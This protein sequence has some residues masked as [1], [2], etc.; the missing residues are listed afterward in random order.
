MVAGIHERPQALDVLP[1]RHVHDDELV[2]VDPDRRRVAL[3]GLQPPY[4][5]G[6]AIGEGIDGLERLDEVCN[7]RVG[8]RC[9]ELGDVE[10]RDLVAQR[11]SLISKR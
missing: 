11:D 4:K 3:V 9:P 8:E 2:V 5:P 10:L 6:V 1:Y 7:E